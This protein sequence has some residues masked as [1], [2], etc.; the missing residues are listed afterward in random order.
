MARTTD[1]AARDRKFFEDR[2]KTAAEAGRKDAHRYANDW[3]DRLHEERLS[4][5]N[6]RMDGFFE[7]ITG[8]QF[9][10]QLWTDLIEALAVSRDAVATW[11]EQM[12]KAEGNS[13]PTGGTMG[14]PVA[15][16]R[17]HLWRDANGKFAHYAADLFRRVS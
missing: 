8:Y 2:L 17:R 10:I 5:E 9:Q 7:H 12:A 11:H 6:V 3:W 15:D 1:R 13:T 4:A 14:N 16:A